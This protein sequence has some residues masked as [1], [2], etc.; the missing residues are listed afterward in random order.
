MFNKREK[1]TE[2]KHALWKGRVETYFFLKKISG[3]EEQPIYL[4]GA[5][6]TVPVITG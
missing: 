5:V 3:L 2:K 4:S 1:I 6:L